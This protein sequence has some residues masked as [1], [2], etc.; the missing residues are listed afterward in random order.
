MRKIVSVLLALFLIIACV[1]NANADQENIPANGTA[2]SVSRVREE[3]SLREANSETYLLSDGSHECVIYAGNKYYRDDN[4]EYVPIDNGIVDKE[5]TIKGISYDFSNKAG[6][7]RFYFENDKP[8]VCVASKN[9]ELA[10]RMAG[11]EA[12]QRE[13]TGWRRS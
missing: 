3:V 5:T 7:Y 9:G 11:T 12:A 4:G 1:G 13:S 6:E 8:S 10:F 2:A